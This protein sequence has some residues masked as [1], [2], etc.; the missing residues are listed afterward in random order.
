MPGNISALHRS[1]NTFD[2]MYRCERIEHR[3]ERI[4]EKDL[5]ERELAG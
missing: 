3:R 5:I 1:V 2:R 4:A